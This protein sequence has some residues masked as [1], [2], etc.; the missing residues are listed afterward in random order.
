MHATLRRLRSL[1]GKAGEVAHLIDTEFIPQLE[2]V[3]G[4]ISYTLVGVGDDEVASLGIFTSEAGATQ[5]NDL[6]MAWAKQR[7][8]DLG[9]SPMDAREGEV[10]VYRTF[11]GLP[12][13]G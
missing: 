12:A 13:T 9:A 1:P 7:L 3:E 2:G 11:A 8:A 4:V 10:L 5:A 6:A